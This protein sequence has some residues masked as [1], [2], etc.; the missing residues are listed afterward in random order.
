MLGRRPSTCAAI[1]AVLFLT[2]PVGAQ[3]NILTNRYDA[4]RTGANLS[5]TTLTAANVT[6]SRFGKL[7]SLPVDGAVYAQP[8]YVSG[9]AV[10]GVAR[11]V[12]FV[13]TMNDK[14]YAFDA[15]DSSPEPLWRR[16]FTNPPSV[17]PV[18]IGDIVAPNMNIVG[19]VGIQSTPVIDASTGTIYLVA[20]TK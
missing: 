16:D 6:S 14:V 7:H 3:L 17:T 12:L 13:A 5:E 4:Q 15:D 20:R 2:V 1:A 19:N 9:L 18:P 11:N 8:L 10:N